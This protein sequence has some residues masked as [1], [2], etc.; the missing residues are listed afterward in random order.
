MSPLLYVR[1]LQ[2]RVLLVKLLYP[3]LKQLQLVAE[4]GLVVV[5]LRVQDH[6]LAE[7]FLHLLQLML[8]TQGVK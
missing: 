8:E 2:L 5:Q 3:V 4:R 6:R 1:Y 7:L